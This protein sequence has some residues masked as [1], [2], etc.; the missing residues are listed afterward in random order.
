[1]EALTSQVSAAIREFKGVSA[2][3]VKS[4]AKRLNGKSP[5]LVL[6]LK[7]LHKSPEGIFRRSLATE[8]EKMSQKL[9]N[10]RQ[11]NRSRM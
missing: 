2:I 7:K 6:L 11:A 4:M 1:M 8:D 10:E 3:P 9:R 5:K